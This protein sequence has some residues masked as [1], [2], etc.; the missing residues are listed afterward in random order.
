[1]K[2]HFLVKTTVSL[3]AIAAGVHG[4]AV[5]T[6]PR[7]PFQR[8]AI[9]DTTKNDVLITRDSV[10]DCG[11]STFENQSSGGSPLVSDCLQLAANIAGGGSW[12]LEIYEQRTLAT[13]GTCAFGATAGP[14]VTYI[15]NQDII[16]L[17]H[18]SV[19]RFTWF[20]L[21]G[22]KGQ[23]PCQLFGYTVSWGIYHA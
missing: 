12:R 16:D 20:G 3:L 8:A 6:G 15:G 13:Y 18:T 5:A 4:M 14:S 19:D 9:D 11:D 23:M 7:T 17:I 1:M 21:V 2:S 22:A 10:N